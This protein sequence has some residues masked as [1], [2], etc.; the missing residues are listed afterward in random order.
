MFV[1]KHADAGTIALKLDERKELFPPGSC[2]D[3]ALY[4]G[5]YSLAKYVPA[6]TWR[7]GAVGWH[8]ASAE[9]KNL[10]NPHTREW[11]AQM[12]RAGVAATAGPV[13]EPYLQAFPL[14]EEF[15]P[16]LMTGRYTLA[17]CWW[18]TVPSASWRMTL[19]GDPLYN[20]FAKA[21]AVKPEALPRGLAPPE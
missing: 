9:A 12:I 18:R 14:P 17:E 20:P 7:R 5:W 4:V 15:F 6:F 16:L 10:R 11:C 19:I 1:R 21:P 8:I 3:A 2:P 13:N